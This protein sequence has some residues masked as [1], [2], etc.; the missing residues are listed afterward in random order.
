M[1]DIVKVN[2]VIAARH[3]GPEMASQ[4]GD[5]HPVG[6]EASLQARRM[7]SVDLAVLPVAKSVHRVRRLLGHALRAVQPVDDLAWQRLVVALPGGEVVVVVVKRDV[8]A[9]VIGRHPRYV[10]QERVE[11]PGLGEV[12]VPRGVGGRLDAVEEF[13]ASGAAVLRLQAVDIYG[14][15][16]IIPSVKPLVLDGGERKGNGCVGKEGSRERK[17]NIKSFT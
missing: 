7:A 15:R 8:E 11:V 14:L 12:G 9:L 16:F 3:G 5:P 1:G 2:H 10:V 6:R 4:F 13:G 17:Q